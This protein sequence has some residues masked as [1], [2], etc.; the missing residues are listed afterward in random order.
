MGEFTKALRDNPAT[1]QLT[2][3]LG[4]YAA[5]KVSSM[6]PNLVGRAVGGGAAGNVAAGATEG[7]TKA[8]QAGKGRLGTLFSTVGGAVKGLFKGRGGTNKR[9][10]NIVEDCFIGVPVETVFEAWTNYHDMATYTKAIESVDE[11][12]ANDE[13][14]IESNWKAKVWWSRRS[15]K[16]TVTG[17]EQ[18]TYIRWKTEGGK[19]TVDGVV[20]FTPIGDNATLVLV[21]IEYRSKGGMEWTAN[22][23]RAV[24]RRVR[25]DLKHF[26]RHLMMTELEGSPDEAP[27]SEASEFGTPEQQSQTNEQTTQESEEATK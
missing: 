9:P 7:V 13:G 15:W 20:S 10:T 26:R 11:T 14:Q 12:G 21:V 4:K 17:Q 2:D 5:A 16:A 23:W 8:G 6:A 1:S 18:D 19:G 3:A 27:E 24:G 25:L 22:R